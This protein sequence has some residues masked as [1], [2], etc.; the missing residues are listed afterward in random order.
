VGRGTYKRQYTLRYLYQ[1][2]QHTEWC[3]KKYVSSFLGHLDTEWDYSQFHEVLFREDLTLFAYSTDVLLL[4]FSHLHIQ[5]REIFGA[6]IHKDDLKILIS[7]LLK[8]QHRE[9]HVHEKFVLLPE[10]NKKERY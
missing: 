8:F 10:R 3:R 7:S 4:R 6:E 1:K 5:Y 2:N 9:L